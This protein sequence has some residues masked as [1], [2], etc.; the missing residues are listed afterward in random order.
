MKNKFEWDEANLKHVA[1]HHVTREEAEQVLGNDPVDLEPQLVDCE[2]RFPSVG[3]TDRGRWLVV[4]TT[5]RQDEIR[6]VTAFDAR[7]GLVE[8]YFRNRRKV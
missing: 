3:V 5:V 2:Q 6:V 1:R 7:K 4:V 8:L